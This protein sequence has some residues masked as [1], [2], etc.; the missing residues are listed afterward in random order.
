MRPMQTKLWL[1]LVVTIL[2]VVPAVVPGADIPEDRGATGLAQ[3]LKRLD[4]VGSVLH[5]GAHP[6]DENSALL[7]WLSRGQGVRTGYLS[8]TRGDGGQ[9]LLGTEL[10]EALGVIRTE[11]LLAARRFDRAQQFFTP[12][13]EFGFSKSADESFEKWGHERVLGDFVRVIRQFRPEII[14]SRFTGTPA[15]GHGHHQVAGIVTQEAF[16]AAAD[17]SRFPE[18]GKPWQAKKLYLNTMARDQQVGIGINVGEFDPVLGRSYSEIAAE[19]RSLHRSQSQGT[20]QEKGPRLTRLQL[21]A[22]SITVEDNADLFAGTI[23]RLPDLAQLEPALGADLNQLQ[24]LIDAIRQKATAMHSADIVPDLATAI[25]LF[26]QIQNKA[27]NEHVQFLL[28]EKEADFHEAAQLAAGLVLDVVASDE[29]VVPG[30]EFNLTIAIVNGGP[31]NFS[32]VR[33]NTD[34]PPGWEAS[35]QGSTGSLEAGQR[36]EQK[37]KVKVAPDATFTQP[38]WLQQP[39]QG[40]RFVWPAGS[41]VNMPFDPPLMRTRS[42]IDYQGTSIVLTKPAEFRDIDNMYGEL[43]RLVKVVPALSVRVSPD[44]AIVPRSGDR[45]KEFTVAVENQ[46][47]TPVESDVRL[48]VPQGWAVTPASSTVKFSR[49]GEKA[50]V[51]FMVTVPDVDGDFTV[52]AI[53]KLG[54]Q[55]YRTGYTVIA[56]PHIETRY[57]YAPA[58]SKVEVF[59]VNTLVSSVGYVEGAGDRVPEALRQLGVSVSMISPEE[60]ANGDLSKYQTIVLGIRAYAANE[61]VRAYN[62]RLLDYVSNGGTLIVQY[63]TYEILDS[64]FGPYPFTIKRPN[65]DRVTDENAELFV[66]DPDERVFNFPNIISDADFQGW[67]QERGLYF[68]ETWD[69]HYKPLLESNDRGEEGKKGGLVEA[70]FGKGTYIYTGYGFFRQLPAGV[71]GAYRMFAN[72]VSIEN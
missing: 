61:N 65:H 12:N 9:N 38:Y 43:R 53:A 45:R 27:T 34:F 13:Y 22:K 4:Q 15:D 41:A 49:Q 17:P 70:K 25:R 14:I 71:R 52:Q 66:L 33:T 68:L 26:K 51:Q 36:F 24:Q 40:D 50:A 8:A 60:L 67:V 47:P 39:K 32:T 44:I 5:T 55:E 18:Y 48:I 62:N 64:Q 63:N 57:I 19:G 29:T 7:A 16:R 11:E 31:Y 6:D 20:A 30:Q 37:F 23:R 59:D 46:S 1:L 54:N 69:P 21:V 28:R 3:A 35:N 42:E 2:V 56:Y 72:L 10:F 58:Q